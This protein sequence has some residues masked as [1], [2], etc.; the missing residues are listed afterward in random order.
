MTPPLVLSIVIP[1]EPFA[2]PR[3]RSFALMKGPKGAKVSVLGPSGAPIVRHYDEKRAVSWKATAQDHMAA[4]LRESEMAGPF[5]P[6]GAV[7]L[8]IRAFYAC[9]KSDR[10]KKPRGLRRKATRPDLDNLAKAVKD[11]AKGV[12]WI[13][14]SQVAE[15]SVS[16]LYAPQ[17]APPHVELRVWALAE[18]VEAEAQHDVAALVR[19]AEKLASLPCSCGRG[20]GGC[21]I[22]F[23]RQALGWDAPKP[24]EIAD[25]RPVVRSLFDFEENAPDAIRALAAPKPAREGES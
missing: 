5:I 20:E 22:C 17:D 15:L 18:E 1:G 9:L 4:A 24:R 16:K 10:R 13:D 2:Q 14:D 7:A 11:A 25:S 6:T 19:I 3:A 12:L 23:A 21:S 8:E